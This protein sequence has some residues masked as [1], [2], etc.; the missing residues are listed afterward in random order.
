MRLIT[1]SS[2]SNSGRLTGGRGRRSSSDA[3][4]CN[5]RIWSNTAGSL[6]S[7]GV[8]LEAQDSNLRVAAPTRLAWISNEHFLATPS[9]RSLPFA[10][11]GSIR[12]WRSSRMNTFQAWSSTGVMSAILTRI[13]NSGSVKFT[14]EGHSKKARTWD[15]EARSPMAAISDFSMSA[16]IG[17][18]LLGR[19]S[20]T[21]LV[22]ATFC[23]P[24]LGMATI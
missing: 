10:G 13:A 8:S 3:G 22:K 9:G 4:G 16:I 21:G 17:V 15:S 5:V 23:N 2:S 12:W 11:P 1:S 14:N 6:R 7:A 18:T 24:M 20:R 19:I